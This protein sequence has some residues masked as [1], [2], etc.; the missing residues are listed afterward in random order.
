MRHRK[1]L[2]LLTAALALAVMAGGCSSR[3]EKDIDPAEAAAAIVEQVDMKDNLMEA[4]GDVALAYYA[5][6]NKV[7]SYSVYVSSSGA[8]AEEVAVLRVGS[9]GDADHAKQIIQTRVDTQSAMF[10]NYQPGEM[11][12]LGAPVIETRGNVVYLVICDDPQQAKDAIAAL[13]K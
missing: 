13:Y 11:V 8:T 5:M 7:K 2:A 1:I 3:G 4:K 9:A 10:E 12:K 6:D